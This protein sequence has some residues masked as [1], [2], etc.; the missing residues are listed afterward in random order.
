MVKSIRTTILLMLLFIIGIVYSTTST[1]ND[2][3]TTTC[4]MCQFVI[5]GMEDYINKNST[6]YAIEKY[7]ESTC[8][9]FPSYQELCNSF[10]EK[11]IPLIIKSIEANFSPLSICQFINYC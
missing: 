5:N 3:S 10:I 1:L 6:L 7:V 8:V 2:I 9:V 4:S 11:Y